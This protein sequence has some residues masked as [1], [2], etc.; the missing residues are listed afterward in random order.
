MVQGDLNG[1][2]SRPIS[3]R[4]AK[5]RPVAA[6]PFPRRRKSIPD[7]FSKLKIEARFPGMTSANVESPTGKLSHRT[8]AA[9]C[10]KRRV[11]S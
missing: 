6:V 1:C 5:Q 9:A 3:W 11:N 7:R 2:D 4:S 8:R 10:A